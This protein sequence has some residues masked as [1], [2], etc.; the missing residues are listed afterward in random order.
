M[1]KKLQINYNFFK[2][3]ILI[4]ISNNYISELHEPSTFKSFK[5]YFY[6]SNNLFI[7]K[8]RKQGMALSI[9]FLTFLELYISTASKLIYKF[10]KNIL[11]LKI[12]FYTHFNKFPFIIYITINVL[13][14]CPTFVYCGDDNMYFMPDFQQNSQVFLMKKPDISIINQVNKTIREATEAFAKQ[15]ENLESSS[16]IHL[17]KR[18]SP[19]KAPTIY[20]HLQ[21]SQPILDEPHNLVSNEQSYKLDPKVL[22]H[23]F[24][25]LVTAKMPV[26]N[27][28]AILNT[29]PI[30]LERVVHENIHFGR[31]GIIGVGTVQVLEIPGKILE[32]TAPII[33]NIYQNPIIGETVQ[34]I[35]VKFPKRDL[36]NT[37]QC[38]IS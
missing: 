22:E 16:K 17:T 10:Q 3:R 1:L 21:N 28:S 31:I 13:R 5:A 34:N 9:F 20:K 32:T 2:H 33:P 30:T 38:C 36:M 24:K 29:T 4:N 37:E 19:A 18:I 23:S 15:E 25:D 7:K 26:K 6:L 8:L 35:P 11:I 14:I 27:K 12:F